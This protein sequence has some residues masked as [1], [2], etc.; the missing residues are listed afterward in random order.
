MNIIGI[1]IETNPFHNGHQYFI[2]EIKKI[3]QPDLII[4][5][6]STSFTMRGEISVLN[7]F[8]KSKAL[9]D[10]GVDIVLEFPFIL[11]TQSSDYFAENAITILNKIGVNHLVCGCETNNIEILERFYSIENSKTFEKVFQSNLENH[12]SY[13][14]NYEKTFSDLGIEQD[15]IELFS[16]PN[17]TLAYQY[18]KTIKKD[19][20]HIQ[21]SLIQRTNSYDSEDL[22][23][24]VVSAKA[25]RYALSNKLSYT[26]YLPFNEL[27]IDLNTAEQTLLKLI[28]YV[29]LSKNS[30]SS[31]INNEGIV[32]Y[33]INNFKMKNCL[34]ELITSLS[35]KRYSKSRIKRT[36]LYMLLDIQNF[37]HKSE[38]LR[39]LGINKVGLNYINSLDKEI[40]NN[41][42]ASVKEINNNDLYYNILDIELQATKLYS[43][44]TNDENLL[45]KEYQLPIRKDL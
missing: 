27:L 40:K 22:N 25:I 30:Y 5:V 34:D 13:K 43:I 23:S 41:I 14:K 20:N 2:N 33:I 11:S 29:C 35:N 21:M 44:L 10:G 18:F 32:N 9:L 38:Y 19:F 42:F 31:L 6:T 16:K 37:Y 24:T 1:I 12:L 4:A 8:D 15:L 39:L 28:N 26:K 45:I 17:F 3:Y 36:L 7:K